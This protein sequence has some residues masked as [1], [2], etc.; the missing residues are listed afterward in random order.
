LN[1]AERRRRKR[2][3]YQVLGISREATDSEIK[4]AFRDL[5]RK[6]HPDISTEMGAED[7]FKEVNEAY[8][9]LSDPKTRARYDRFGFAGIGH[10]DGK[11]GFGAVVD[12]LEDMLGEIFKRRKSKR[13][14]RDLRYTMEVTLEEAAFGCE[15][16]IEVPQ[17]GTKKKSFTVQVPP[18]SK[19]GDVR[20]IQGEGH[21][22][23]N[24]GK[25]GDLNVIVRVVEHPFFTREGTDVWCDV[26]ISFPQAALGAVIDV[27]TLR[28]KVRMRI[29]EGTQSGRVFR[30]RGKGISK[31][32]GQTAGDQMVKVFLETPTGLT[33]KQRQ[34]LESFAK[35][36]GDS[37]A[38]PQTKSFLDSLRKFF[39][40]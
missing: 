33:A 12:N 39:K 7:R 22:G 26:P 8:A 35:E 27:P 1:V 28:G 37:V 6:Y 18:G 3:Y 29:P 20:R 25:S 11:E 36:S 32:K 24:G 4:R 2:D 15:K 16:S 38:H 17:S 19:N 31:G 9:V 5:A 34:L 13:R 14:G 21:L 23:Q 30:M 10:D 40:E